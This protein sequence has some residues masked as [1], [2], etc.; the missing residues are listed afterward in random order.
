MRSTDDV[1]TE[2]RNGVSTITSVP[3]LKAAALCL[4][5]VPDLVRYGSKPSRELSKSQ[6]LASRLAEHRRSYK[7][8]VAYPPHQ[9][10][11][12]NLEPERLW[13][14]PSPWWQHQLPE[15]SREGPDGEIMSQAEFYGL[16]KLCDDFNL[17]WLINSYAAF[18]ADLLARHPLFASD[19]ARLHS[20]A[21]REEVDAKINEN[22]AIGLYDGDELVGCM[23]NGER[24]DSSQNAAILLENLAAKASAVLAL[25]RALHG[26]GI[27]PAAV[28][29][30]FGCGEEAIGDRY[31]RGGGNLAKAVGERVGC[32]NATGSDVKAFCCAPNHAIT[33][34]SGL[35]KA[36]LFRS[37]AVVG[38]ASLAKLGMKYQGHLRHKMPI[39]EDVL[40][41]IA[42]VITPDDH[43]SPVINLDCIG[44][45]TIGAG[46]T[47]EEIADALVFKPL[48]NCGLNVTDIDRFATELHN[49]ELTL[50]Q[51][52]GNVPQTNY[53]LLG[54]LASRRGQ[55]NGDVEQFVRSHG[56]PGFSPTQG[57]I[58]SAVPFLGHA[59]RKI[60]EGKINRAFFYAKGSLF[61][62]RMTTMADGFSFL[63]QTNHGHSH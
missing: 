14:L 43:V 1:A 21:T 2:S 41:S 11:I 51:G 12:G 29:Y 57:H 61:L 19:I 7:D 18:V 40:A 28:E 39:L 56:L 49:P 46:S 24:E 30:I 15:A 22:S 63:L 33:I 8:A 6:G 42:V 26:A 32:C 54:S 27:V 38:G 60:L 55:I 3:V 17:L 45:H 48:Q 36:G 34:G 53:R 10:F 58:A 5:H 20:E 37:I 13:E 31:Q 47:Q 9:V 44:R 4:A 62:G 23:C 16:M 59:R 35:V 50:P 52:S 25:R